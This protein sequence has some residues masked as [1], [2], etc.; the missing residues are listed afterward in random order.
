VVGELPTIRKSY[1]FLN[2]STFQSQFREPAL[3]LEAMLLRDARRVFSENHVAVW[4]LDPP[5]QTVAPLDA[6]AP[7]E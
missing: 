6:Q 4:R 7:A 1:A 5:T 2:E 3:R